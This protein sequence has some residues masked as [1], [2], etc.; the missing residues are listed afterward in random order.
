MVPE[1]SLAVHHHEVGLAERGLKEMGAS[2][3]AHYTKANHA[4]S[5]DGM[6]EGRFVVPSQI[7]FV[8]YAQC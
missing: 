4:R 8:S 6:W 1:R 2:N 3:V 7:I 5:V